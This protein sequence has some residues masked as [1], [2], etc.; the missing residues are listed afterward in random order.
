M[1]DN[2][3][4]YLADHYS[5]VKTETGTFACAHKTADGLVYSVL[6]QDQHT[7]LEGNAPYTEFK[8]ND[9]LVDS[10]SAAHIYRMQCP[11]LWDCI[12]TNIIRQVIRANQAKNMYRTFS[13]SIGEKVSLTGNVHYYL[14]PSLQRVLEVSDSA[15]QRMGMSF[16]KDA[17]RNAAR[18]ILEHADRLEKIQAPDLLDELMKIR[19]IG[20]WTARA[21]VADYTNELATY[22]YGDAAIRLYAREA[23]PRHEWPKEEAA[24]IQELHKVAGAENMSSSIATLIMI[25]ET[26]RDQ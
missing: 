20:S 24:F 7:L 23:L 15:Y 22:P 5:W 4:Y 17:L 16:K 6:S 18:F 19:R 12:G 14:F 26:R 9:K 25:H 1:K 2:S 21:T 8:K 11:N 13:K 10:P 3:K